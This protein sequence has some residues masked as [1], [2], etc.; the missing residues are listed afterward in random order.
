[1]SQKLTMT[2]YNP[3]FSLNDSSA[4]SFALTELAGYSPKKNKSVKRLI[5]GSKTTSAYPIQ[6]KLLLPL[7]S[8]AN[9]KYA[10]RDHKH[11]KETIGGCAWRGGCQGRTDN[12]ERGGTKQ[13][14]FAANTVN[15]NAEKYL[16]W[17]NSQR[18]QLMKTYNSC[19]YK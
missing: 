4:A 1:M 10:T 17:E 7:T 15:N 13:P 5:L 18:N 8:D 14:D 9:T 3:R 19:W 6:S 16:T 2:K 11:P 12:D